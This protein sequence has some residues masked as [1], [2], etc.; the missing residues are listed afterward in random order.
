MG[1]GFTDRQLDVM[2]I[3]WEEGDATVREAKEKIGDDLAYTSVLTVFQTLDEEGHVDYEKEGRA[4]RYHPTVSR[5][6]AGQ[7]AVDY[8][9]RRVFGGSSSEFL[10]ALA[11]LE[12]VPNETA[13][14][15]RDLE[16]WLR[17]CRV[18]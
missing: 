1:F 10:G 3:L 18:R 5:E 8:V 14:E 7:E 17:G 2:N 6:E 15:I 11:D 16:I 13:E 4:Y 9:L 12:A